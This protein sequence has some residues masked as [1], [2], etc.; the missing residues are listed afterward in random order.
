[1]KRKLLLRAAEI[2]AEIPK[3]QFDLDRWLTGDASECILNDKKVTKKAKCDTIA[4]AGGWLGITKEF[5]DRGLHFTKDQYGYDLSFTSKKLSTTDP[6]E[7]LQ[8]TFDLDYYQ[9]YAL[10]DGAGSG[11]YDDDIYTKHGWDLSDRDLFQYRVKKV[12]NEAK[13]AKK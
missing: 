4:C 12:I 6:F 3:K 8:A 1:M 2:L 9:A 5:N 11:E 7:A 10:F 13:K